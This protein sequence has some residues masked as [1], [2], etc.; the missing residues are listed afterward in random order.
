[1]KLIGRQHKLVYI[2]GHS[3]SYYCV[4]EASQY[5]SRL[6]TVRKMILSKVK[7]M[8]KLKSNYCVIL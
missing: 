4:T 5:V 3:M 7:L 8:P 2:S 1:M 6:F